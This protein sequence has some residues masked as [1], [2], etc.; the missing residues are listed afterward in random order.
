[1]KAVGS[2]KAAITATNAKQLVPQMS[3]DERF[4]SGIGVK[5]PKNR[6]RRWRLS[7]G[8]NSMTTPNRA[9]TDA[10]PR[11]MSSVLVFRPVRGRHAVRAPGQ[12]P[13]AGP[14]LRRFDPD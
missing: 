8:A 11:Q 3:V 2:G 1:M 12:P 6:A 9:E 10:R 13:A 7:G 14:V 4:M 5:P